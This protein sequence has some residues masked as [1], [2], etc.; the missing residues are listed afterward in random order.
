VF[1]ITLSRLFSE[2]C[3]SFLKSYLLGKKQRFII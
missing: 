1:M 3:I 2:V